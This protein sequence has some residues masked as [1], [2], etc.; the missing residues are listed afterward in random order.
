[1][2]AAVSGRARR[3]RSLT[4]WLLLAVIVAGIVVT[5]RMGWLDPP[6]PVDEHGHKT[7]A[8]ML[9]PVDLAQIAAVEITVLDVKSRF[10]R[11]AAGAWFHHHHEDAEAAEAPHE[12]VTDPAEAELI[13]QALGVLN[14]TRIARQVGSGAR[15]EDYG[16]TRPEVVFAV[17][18]SGQDKPL[19]RYMVGDLEPDEFRRYVLIFG[20]FSI[21]TIP[22][23][24][25]ENLRQLVA[26]FRPEQ[27]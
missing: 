22:D 15:G 3:Y 6:Q 25:V 17:F 10:E 9:L 24:Q 13:A 20:A 21:V 8:T 5:D 2:A 16:V 11:D 18:G 14:R 27:G 4:I 1:M 26:A 23:Y 12:H 7:A 19:A